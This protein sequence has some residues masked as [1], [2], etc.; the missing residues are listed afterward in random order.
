V[1]TAALFLY[2]LY[3]GFI[4]SDIDLPSEIWY[5]DDVISWTYCLNSISILEFDLMDYFNRED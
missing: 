3:E 1:K 2:R 5:T 4:Y